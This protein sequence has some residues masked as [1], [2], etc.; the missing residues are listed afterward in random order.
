MLFALVVRAVLFEA[1]DEATRTPTVTRSQVGQ[2][3]IVGKLS[4]SDGI[5]EGLSGG[6]PRC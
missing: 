6:C 5:G 4:I 2:G 1:I 3:G